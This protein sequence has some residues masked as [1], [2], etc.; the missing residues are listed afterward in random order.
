MVR[1]TSKMLIREHSWPQHR[2]QAQKETGPGRKGDPAV[3][4]PQESS[5]LLPCWVLELECPFRVVLSWGEWMEPSSLCTDQA[6]ESGFRW[7]T[8]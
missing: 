2:G 7:N 8:A 3:V 1:V 4:W 6:L 5:Q